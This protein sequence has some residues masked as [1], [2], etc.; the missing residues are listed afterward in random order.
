[1][2][3]KLA[4]QSLII[5]CSLF[6]MLI[7]ANQAK[8]SHAMGADLWYQCIDPST[9]TYVISLRFYRDCFG[10]DVPLEATVILASASCGQ[11][12]DLTLTQVPC[13]TN[14]SG[15]IACEVSP[16]CPAFIGQSQCADITNP[17]P[18]VQAYTYTDTF[19][20]TMAC[21]D[22]VFSWDEC[23]RNADITNLHTPDNYDL[24]VQAK[25]NNLLSNYNSSP[26][27]TTLPVPFICSSQPYS[28]NHG[29]VDVD[30]D[31]LV[32]ILINPLSF[33]I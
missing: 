1:M 25:L 5:F 28:Y 13:G 18:G 19:Q 29:A 2:T 31:S 17:Y 11:S 20:L 21:S 6:L 16:L 22:W 23:C 7:T 10:I 30:G 33:K 8:A 26:V 15:G 27:F 4:T 9:N 24:Y 32:Y 3:R 12:I 14:N